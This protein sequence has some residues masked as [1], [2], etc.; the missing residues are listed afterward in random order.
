MQ[1]LLKP[2]IC[3]IFVVQ[4]NVVYLKPLNH[5]KYSTQMAPFVQDRQSVKILSAGRVGGGG[6]GGGVENRSHFY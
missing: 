1:K 6:G 2:D 4:Y 5:C 3:Y